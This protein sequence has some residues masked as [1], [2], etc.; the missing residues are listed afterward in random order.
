M[1]EPSGTFKA[2]QIDARTQRPTG[3]IRQIMAATR[4]EALA[5]LLSELSVADSAARIGPNGRI[6]Q[7]GDHAWIMLAEI[8][9]APLADP[10]HV[11]RGG[12]KHRRTS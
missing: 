6:V 12:A 2:I 7:V 10:P 3:E 9:P 4:S 8:G 5:A 11:R 1:A